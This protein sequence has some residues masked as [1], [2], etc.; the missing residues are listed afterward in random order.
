MKW[1]SHG[2]CVGFLFPSW[3][4]VLGTRFEEQLWL[5]SSTLFIG[6]ISHQM[7][8]LLLLWS[9]E[10][11]RSLIMPYCVLK[12][13]YYWLRGFGHGACHTMHI[14]SREQL[15][16][17]GSLFPSCDS[18]DSGSVSSPVCTELPCWPSCIVLRLLGPLFSLTW[19]SFLT[20][21]Y[22]DMKF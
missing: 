15:S 8:L 1:F 17:L 6:L 20:C 18:W 2:S 7:I 9:S 14:E 12:D 10:T 5:W 13:T 4:L 3:N 22:W 11:L 19:N 16:G 21:F